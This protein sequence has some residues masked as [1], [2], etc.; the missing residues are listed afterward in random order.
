MIGTEMVNFALMLM[1]WKHLALPLAYFWIAFL[2]G[3]VINLSVVLIK[4][5]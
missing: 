5:K 1:I 4:R 2:V 3:W